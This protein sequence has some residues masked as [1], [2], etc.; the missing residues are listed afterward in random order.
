M[1]T[2]TEAKQP[3]LSVAGLRKD[4]GE[5]TALDGL[6]FE[7]GRGQTLALLGP[8]GAGK[9]TLLRIL[10]PLLRP[11]PRAGA[12]RGRPGPGTGPRRPRRP[13][14]PGGEPGTGA[15][16]G[17][18]RRRR[19]M[20]RSRDAFAAILG[21]DLRTELRTLR[22]VPAMALFAV[23]SFVIFRFGLDRTS[24]SGSL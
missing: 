24:L 14:G 18:A 8:N 15:R 21:K 10:A 7:L 2:A 9:T 17:A 19:W 3:A 22:S 12:L 6:G 20:T 1:K 13:G 11:G 4:F 16:P 5:R 23:T